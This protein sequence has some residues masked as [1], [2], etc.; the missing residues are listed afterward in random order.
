M[1]DGTQKYDD[2][3]LLLFNYDIE[4]AFL[5]SFSDH[6]VYSLPSHFFNYSFDA[7]HYLKQLQSFLI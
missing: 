7:Y 4:K 5:F 6:Q 2:G 1:S 3:Q